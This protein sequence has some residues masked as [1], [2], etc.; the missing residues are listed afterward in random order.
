MSIQSQINAALSGSTVTIAAGTYAEAFTVSK[1]L[2]LVANGAVLVRPPASAWNAV[3]ITA[4]DVTIE[5][6]DIAGA[7]GDGIE[8]NNVRGVTVLRC[9]ITGCGESGV[10]TNGCDLVRV[11]GCTLIGNARD[12]WCSGISLYQNRARGVTTTGFRNVIRDNICRDN[13]TLPAGGPHTDGNGIIIDDFQNN[14]NGSTAGNYPYT[15][16]VENNL[17]TGNGGK[18]IQVTWSD[19]VTVR[20]NTCHG[21]NRDVNNDGTWRG[22]LSISQSKAAAVERNIVHCVRGTGRLAQNRAIDNTST[23]NGFNTT[24]WA[25]N[26]GWDA[27]GTPSVRTDGGN[28]VSGVT[29]VDPK[30]DANWLPTITT[31]AG[32]RPAG[33]PPPPPPP[34]DPEEPTVSERLD[35]LK[36]ALDAYIAEMDGAYDVLAARMAALEARPIDP[37]IAVRLDAAEAA[38][39]A[40]IAFEDDVRNP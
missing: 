33:A 26:V 34:P 39:T 9:K 28:A 19:K 31:D 5:G 11:E 21:N 22:D 38:I 17:C 23:T 14:Q 40:L 16:L 35:A 25:G 3:S 18:G 7:R 37:Q 32:W 13:I 30:L 4:G 2:R 27:A 10:Q 36:A 8:A 20:G 12:T 1:A 6:F 15:T 29:W 24:T